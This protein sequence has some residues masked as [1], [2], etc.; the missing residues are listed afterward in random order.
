MGTG[1]DCPSGLYRH[2][3]GKRES[4]RV[5]YILYA[6]VYIFLNERAVDALEILMSMFESENELVSE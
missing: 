5:G 2:M 4:V 3:R 1:R 6:Q